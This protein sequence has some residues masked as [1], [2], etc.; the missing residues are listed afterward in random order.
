MWL[1][2]LASLGWVGWGWLDARLYQQRQER[3]L[4]QALAEADGGAGG[5]DADATQGRADAP[6]A[7]EAALLD[8]VPGELASAQAW[9]RE[10]APLA[11][12][13]DNGAAPGADLDRPAQPGTPAAPARRKQRVDDARAALDALGLIVVPRLHM[14]V[15]VADGIDSR[16]LRRAAGHIPGTSRLGSGGNV[17]IAGHRDSFFRPL[18]DVRVGDEVVVTTPGAISR[19]RVEWAEVVPPGDTSS[20]LPTGYSALTLVTC[21]PFH[22]VGTAPD[23][24]VVRARLIEARAATAADAALL[25]APRRGR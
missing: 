6:S 12:G 22:Y 20:L 10:G 3:L 19:Y 14:S 17:G 9:P 25:S 18:R 7:W 13:G 23:R 8:S 11:A 21:Y 4:E 16:T 15:M 24:Y 2:G 1:A 5:A